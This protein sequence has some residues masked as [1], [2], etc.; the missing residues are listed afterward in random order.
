MLAYSQALTTKFQISLPCDVE[1]ESMTDD[2]PMTFHKNKR[3]D[4]FYAICTYEV[5]ARGKECYLFNCGDPNVCN[6]TSHADYSVFVLQQP[7]KHPARTSD[8]ATTALSSATN[9]QPKGT[10]HGR[11]GP[12]ISCT[13]ENTICDSGLC[14]CQAGWIEKMHTCVRSVCKKPDLQFQCNDGSACIAVYDVCNGI[15][16]CRDESDEIACDEGWALRQGL[17][18]ARVIAKGRTVLPELSSLRM[19][20]G[21]PS[22]EVDEVSCFLCALSSFSPD[23]TLMS[24]MILVRV[25]FRNRVVCSPLVSGA[26]DLRKY[27]STA[28]DRRPMTHKPAENNSHPDLVPKVDHLYSRLIHSL[29]HQRKQ[30]QSQPPPDGEMA[31]APTVVP[32]ARPRD[33]LYTLDANDLEGEL[34]SLRTGGSHQNPGGGGGGGD[35]RSNLAAHTTYED[36]LS[37]TRRPV[38]VWQL[39]DPPAEADSDTSPFLMRLVDGSSKDRRHRLEHLLGTY[40]SAPGL[41]G[42]QRHPSLAAAVAT[43]PKEEEEEAVVVPP[44]S[45]HRRLLRPPPPAVFTAP[46]K[47]R[48]FRLHPLLERYTRARFFSPPEE[49]EP[50]VVEEE[51]EQTLAEPLTVLPRNQLSRRRT[52]LSYRGGARRRGHGAAFYEENGPVTKGGVRE[53]EMSGTAAVRENTERGKSPRFSCYTCAHH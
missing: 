18:E 8:S 23:P 12:T 28:G 22:T 53:T 16:E 50:A 41:L 32:A 43:M 31:A 19:S 9:S 35:S 52:P 14:V 6:F 5:F 36:L 47:Y 10:L 30:E 42:R 15:A 45:R 13:D 48:G 11:C 38:A 7:I 17:F 39:D 34:H 33:F 27:T 3:W 1:L 4:N 25:Q 26:K 44:S 2:T 20:L 40:G 21:R 37:R 46:P 29:Y 24:S 49:E 51:R